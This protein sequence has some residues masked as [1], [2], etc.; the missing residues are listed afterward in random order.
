MT[1]Q[2]L[3][4]GTVAND[5]TGDTLR[6]AGLKIGQNFSEIYNKLGDGASLMTLI[7]FDSSG[8]IFDGETANV[9]K[10]ALRVVNPTASNTVQIPDHTGILTMDTNTQTL[11]NKTLTSPVL[12][13]PQIN[14]TSANHQYVFAVSELTADRTVTLPL[15]TSDD[16]ITFNAHAQTLTNKTLNV[17]VL[18]DPKI[19]G[20]IDDASGNELIELAT[21]ASAVNHV[22]ITN[23]ANANDP[24]ISGTG[25]DNNVTLALDAKG[26]GAIALNSRVQLKTQSIAS[27]GGTVNA[28]DPVTLFTSG[29]TG[30]HSI[31]SAVQ[32]TTGIVKHIVASGAGTQTINENSNIA[33]GSTLTIPQNGSITL[34]WFTNT[35]IVTNLQGG[36]TL[37]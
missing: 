23:S 3:N 13:T 16:E 19:T 37:A 14:D 26:N 7:D 9:H 25:G 28:S 1:L 32:G 15:L 30:T 5:G 6:T 11:T 35:W 36:A 21:T 24:K 29:S 34:M 31:S 2:V 22:K 20:A 12:T 18:N 10:T 27:T 33:G 8:I 17:S 4:R